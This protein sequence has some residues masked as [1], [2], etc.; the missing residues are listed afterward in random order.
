MK[1]TLIFDFDGT[2]SDT[3]YS[4][5]D[6]INIT[7]RNYGYP[8]KSY[9]EV[10]RAIGNGARKL[11]SRLM[12]E[13]AARNEDLVSEVFEYYQSMYFHTCMNAEC[14]DGMLET[15]KELKRRGYIIAVLSNK[16][17]VHVKR[18]TEGVIPQGILSLAI[19]QREGYPTKPDPTVPL[20]MVKELGGEAANA[21]FIGDSD[22][23][24]ITAKNSG[25]MSVGCDWGYRDREVLA[26]CG[27]DV[28]VSRPTELLDVFK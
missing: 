27:A 4:I 3:I 5:R 7:M 2:I 17:D 19:G 6:A 26:A 13:D 23:D 22:V 25:M 12:P 20:M 28:L 21:A 18:I 9:D 11:V 24:I 1:K 14:Y 10:K 15:L 16:S 8:E